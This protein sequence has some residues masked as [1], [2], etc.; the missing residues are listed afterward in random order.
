MSSPVP[1]SVLRVFACVPDLALS[2]LQVSACK[3]SFGTT[4]EKNTGGVFF[5]PPLWLV[6]PPLKNLA[7]HIIPHGHVALKLARRAK[8]RSV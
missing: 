1:P 6:R 4:Q 3:C 7:T 5:C 8:V 2:D